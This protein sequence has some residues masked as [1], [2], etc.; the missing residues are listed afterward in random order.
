MKP[1]A[2]KARHL[3]ERAAVRGWLPLGLALLL[4]PPERERREAHQ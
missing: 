2:T 3:I 4:A 1:L